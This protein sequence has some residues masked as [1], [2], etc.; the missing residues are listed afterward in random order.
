MCDAKKGQKMMRADP[1]KADIADHDQTAILGG[2]VIGEQSGGIV[3]IPIK[4]V[5][6]PTSGDTFGGFAQVRRIRRNPQTFEKKADALE[7]T[8][9]IG[10]VDLGDVSLFFG[11]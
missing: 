3:S 2:K 6:L 9:G 8:L 7:H 5:F 11:G 1:M 4:E 10:G